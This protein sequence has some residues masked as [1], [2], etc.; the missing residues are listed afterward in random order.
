MLQIAHACD[1]SGFLPVN[2]PCAESRLAAV[3]MGLDPGIGLLHVDAPNRDSLACDLMEPVRPSV[4][5][6]LNQ[7]AETW[8]N[9]LCRKAIT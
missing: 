9:V 8:H 2:V 1:S 3:A 5:G 7:S 4:D 6:Q